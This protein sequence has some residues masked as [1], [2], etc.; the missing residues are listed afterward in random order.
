VP[1]SR[2]D[3]LHSYQYS[4]QRVVSALVTHDP[5]PSRSPLRRAGSATLVSLLVAAIAVGGVAAYALITGNK[6]V[7]PRNENVVFVEKESGAQ[8]IYYSD[9]DRLHPVLNFTSGL[10]IAGTSGKAST[11]NVARKALAGVQLGVP[12][13]IPSAPDS[14]PAAK[15]LMKDPWTICSIMDGTGV[16]KPTKTLLVIGDPPADGRVPVS[17]VGA[18][19]E[20]LMVSDPVGTVYLIYGNRRFRIPPDKVQPT[21]TALGWNDQR[22]IPVSAAFI[23][24]VPGGRDLVPPTI[25]GWGGPST[26]TVP[27]A[28]I[29]MMLHTFIDDGNRQVWAIVMDDGVA[30]LT[31]V[32][33]KQLMGDPET[34]GRV[35]A[36]HLTDVTEFGKLRRSRTVLTG[37]DVLDGQPTSTPDLLPASQR[38]CLTMENKADGGE[39]VV[40]IDPTVPT[41]IDIGGKASA[42]DGARIDSISV[43]RG[44]GVL[45][46]AAP[47]NVAPAG[48]GTISLVLDTGTHYPLASAD[49]PARL[50]YA[51]VK[52][53]QYPSE[54]VKMLPIGPA[55]DPEE[56]RKSRAGTD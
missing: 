55:L 12:M 40:R 5:D 24:A 6:K 34:R 20:T 48:T 22:P 43:P 3:Q 45:V 16:A 23:N 33:A 18:K 36:S 13:G 54:L 49:V 51:G 47:S 29:G 53:L 25:Y 28:T 39:A 31:E 44:R 42:V 7:D 15:D 1:S 30:D 2:Q 9:D 35:G 27:N 4:Q 52:P 38:V 41:G 56:A 46:E 19:G 50:G 14:L 10:L 8:Y 11:S 17:A 21:K 32:Q 26:A 37:A